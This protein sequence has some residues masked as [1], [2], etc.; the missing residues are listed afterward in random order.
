[1]RYRIRVITLME[2]AV[3]VFLFTMWMT[4]PQEVSGDASSA[5]IHIS[6]SYMA[7]TGM[8]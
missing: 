4:S 5:E 3:V 2:L 8:I 7:D 1:M 6:I